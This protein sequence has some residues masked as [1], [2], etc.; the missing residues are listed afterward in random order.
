MKIR[1][2]PEG[3]VLTPKP[4][5]VASRTSRVVF[6]GFSVLILESVSRSFA[7]LFS[8][9]QFRTRMKL[10]GNQAASVG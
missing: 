3:R 4:L 1:F 7:T 8:C 10:D 6:A 5:S 9:S 2:R